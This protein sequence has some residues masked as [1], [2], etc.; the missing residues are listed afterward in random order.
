MLFGDADSAARAEESAGRDFLHRGVA[1]ERLVEGDFEGARRGFHHN[2]VDCFMVVDAGKGEGGFGKPAPLHLL[3]RNFLVRFAEVG[4][5]GFLTGARVVDFS[6]RIG[7][8]FVAPV[9]D[10]ERARFFKP[11]R[12]VFL[13]VLEKMERLGRLCV[14]NSEVVGAERRLLVCEGADVGEGAAGVE[15]VA[16]EDDG[17]HTVGFFRV[18]DADVHGKG[19]SLFVH[20]GERSCEAGDGQFYGGEAVGSFPVED[21]GVLAD[22]I[23]REP[24]EISGEDDASVPV[25][26]DDGGAADEG[27]FPPLAAGVEVALSG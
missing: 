9:K 12:G 16:V 13:A 24:V 23:E 8:W 6:V 19:Q 18:S 15:A 7:V 5:E 20:A 25:F 2:G 17:G 22:D 3:F 1:R 4:F 27:L 10:G 21:E 11:L 26:V 14:R